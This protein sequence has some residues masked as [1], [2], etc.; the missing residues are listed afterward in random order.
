M[1]PPVGRTY[2]RVSELVV[3]NKVVKVAKLVVVLAN[4]VATFACMRPEVRKW[5]LEST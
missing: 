5:I 3:E 4:Q 2:C 1:G